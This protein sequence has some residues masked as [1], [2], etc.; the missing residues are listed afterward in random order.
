[1]R[2]AL[3]TAALLAFLLLALA[4]PCYL[5]IDALFEKGRFT[6]AHYQAVLGDDRLWGLLLNTVLVGGLT[7]LFT[8]LVGVPFG[9]ALSRVRFRF[10][11]FFRCLYLVPVM[12]PTYIMGITWTEHVDFY[13]LFGSVFLLSACYW[14]ITALFAG[15]GFNGVGRELEEAAL[16]SSGRWRS[17]FRVT[18]RL[19]LPSILAGELFVFILSIGDFGIPDFL[20]FTSTKTFQVYTL[21]IFNR[22]SVLDQ[23]GEAVA[24]ALPVVVL[25]VAAV[26][27]IVRLEGRGGGG[28]ISGGFRAPHTRPAGRLAPLLYLFMAVVIGVSTV[29][30]LVT[31]LQWVKGAGGPLEI[32][33]VVREAFSTAGVDTLNTI[34]SAALAALLMVAVGFFI[35]HGIERN[36][37]WTGRL[38][39]FSALLPLA[40][41][42]VMLAVADIRIWNHPGNPL[43]DLV[44]G[45]Q[46]EL[47]MIYFA[48]FIP[49]AILSLRAGI[50]QVDPVLEEASYMSGRGYGTTM[51]RVLMPVVWGSICAAFLLSYILCMR[52]LD[53]VVLVSAGNDTLPMRIYSQIHTSRDVGI[54]ALSV[55]L[56]FTLL[57]PPT[58][59]R[60]L[61]RGKV[62]VL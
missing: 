3:F 25:A 34:L 10:K 56:V 53:S 33:A 30:P 26:I 19:A 15:K 22:W 29:V 4:P 45:S 21:E 38:L 52:E 31:L 51:V 11:T 6:L 28:S 50:R 14:P 32:T 9:Y 1:M 36:R 24:S 62:D 23:T 7:C 44:Y 55:M 12:L 37:G 5:M 54:G 47:I 40:F 39:A 48:R 46:A 16:L 49:I 27:G 18:L 8:F 61:V 2:F 58:V 43:S 41:P 35:A 59:Y 13:G 42:P 20:S 17:F 57:V 60:L